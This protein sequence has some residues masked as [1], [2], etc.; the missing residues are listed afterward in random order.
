[1]HADFDNTHQILPPGEAAIATQPLSN[2]PHAIVIP[3]EAL[4]TA[5][6]GDTVY[7]IEHGHAVQRTVTIG[8][9]T[10]SGVQIL[11]V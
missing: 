7:V 5:L 2:I 11:K 6:T 4:T 9:S 3:A 8:V 1:M 10:H